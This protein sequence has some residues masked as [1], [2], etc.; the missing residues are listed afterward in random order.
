MTAAREPW[1]YPG[2]TVFI[3]YQYN[4]GQAPR[5]RQPRPEDQPQSG[6]SPFP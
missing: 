2:R 6:G 1:D 4:Y 3:T 5:V